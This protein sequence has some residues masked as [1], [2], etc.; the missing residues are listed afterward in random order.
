MGRSEML[1]KVALKLKGVGC[2]DPSE[3]PQ[4]ERVDGLEVALSRLDVLRHPDFDRGASV[5]ILANE[6]DRHV[7][8]PAPSAEPV[9]KHL[10]HLLVRVRDDVEWTIFLPHERDQEASRKRP[11]G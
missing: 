10:D 1:M 6:I 2:L 9:E 3:Q 11:E 4:L 8:L 5:F 7:T